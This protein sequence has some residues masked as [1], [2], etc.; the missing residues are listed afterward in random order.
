MSIA[1]S[2]HA[3]MD[4]FVR[5]VLNS[6]TMRFA[7]FCY[8]CLHRGPSHQAYLSRS[9]NPWFNLAL[10]D[11]LFRTRDPDTPVCLLY[12]NDRCVVVGRNQ[13][14]SRSAQ[15][16]NVCITALALIRRSTFLFRAERSQ[17]PWKELNIA[18]MR[19][20]G[21]PLVRRRS[22][23][24]TVYHVSCLVSITAV[25]ALKLI[26]A[27]NTIVIHRIWA[28]QTIPSTSP[29][30]NSPAVRTPNWSRAHSTDH[31][32]TSKPSL[33]RRAILQTASPR[34]AQPTARMSTAGTISACAY[35]PVRVLRRRKSAKFPAALTS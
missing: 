20:S 34:W 10:E 15:R 5:A 23:G 31:P 11:H 30:M 28:I 8:F 12:R 35:I 19:Q 24:G 2:I 32:S 21:I 25:P 3:H 22:G 1:H 29:E 4:S 13:V 16:T 17:N 14:R 27:R 26:H 6:E 7:Q 18:A 33:A 9:N